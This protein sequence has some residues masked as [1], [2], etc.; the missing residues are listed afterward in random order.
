MPSFRTLL[1]ASL[2][3][4]GAAATVQAQTQFEL[5]A[6]ADTSYR[7][8]D[9][10]LNATYR[11]LLASYRSDTAAVRKLRIAQRAWIVFRDAQV[12]AT[13]PAN[14]KQAAYGSIYPMCVL[15]L[16]QELTEARLAQLRAALEPTEGDVC[17][18]GPSL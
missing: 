9:S 17:S 11:R 18:G 2:L 14:D 1:A 5:R 7:R 3:L 15:A 16:L 10:T 8:A 6:Q 12:E 13:F 4:V